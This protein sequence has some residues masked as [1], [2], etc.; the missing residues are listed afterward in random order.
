VVNDDV[1]TGWSFLD[2][3]LEGLGGFETRGELM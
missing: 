1:G 2:G 3:N